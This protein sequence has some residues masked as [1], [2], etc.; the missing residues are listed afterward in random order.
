MQRLSFENAREPKRLSTYVH[1][2][3]QDLHAV[4]S[5]T[6]TSMWQEKLKPSGLYSGKELDDLL[7]NHRRG[8][9]STFGTRKSSSPPKRAATVTSAPTYPSP[10]TKPSNSE[11]VSKTMIKLEHS[12]S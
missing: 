11:N 9:A 1:S 4:D 2:L 7:E 10:K 5:S 3:V 12:Y 6:M 8:T